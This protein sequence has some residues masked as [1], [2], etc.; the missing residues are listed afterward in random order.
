MERSCINGN[1]GRR[2]NLWV[3]GMVW[4]G[5]DGTGRVCTL[6]SCEE[7]CDAITEGCCCFLTKFDIHITCESLAGFSSFGLQQI[8][9]GRLKG[10][11]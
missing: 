11:R 2:G 9:G 4:K 3:V 8:A 10:D 1:F 7:C 6:E 5:E